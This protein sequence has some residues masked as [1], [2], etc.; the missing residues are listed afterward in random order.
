MSAKTN[1]RAA[2]MEATITRKSEKLIN[3]DSAK[4]RTKA[5][6]VTEQI[7][8]Q[9]MPA[10]A[11]E[12]ISKAKRGK[13]AKPKRVAYKHNEYEI[14]HSMGDFFFV[15]LQTGRSCSDD[16]L[17]DALLGGQY[18]SVFKS[19]IPEH[20]PPKVEDQLEQIFYETQNLDEA[21]NPPNRST[22][23][24]DIIR[25]GDK[26]WTVASVGWRRLHMEEWE[27]DVL[28]SQV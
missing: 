24:G 28:K 22:S 14:F 21:W 2:N 11:A 20:F 27:L 25:I 4:K 13:K 1:R 23:V 12:T 16:R 6:E 17:I 19:N 10:E 18:A 9:D 26:F 3:I 8:N 7:S 15:A 5:Q